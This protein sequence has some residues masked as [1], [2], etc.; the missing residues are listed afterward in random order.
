[1]NTLFKLSIT[2]ILLLTKCT[3]SIAQNVFETASTKDNFLIESWWVKPFDLEYKF[4][5]FN[6]SAAEYNYESGQVGFMSYSILNYNVIKGFGPAI[7]TRLLPD[8]LVPLGGL[9]YSFYREKFFLTANFTSEFKAQPD[10][11][12][13]S[14]I[15][16]RPPIT[17]KLKGFFQGQ[18][19]FN[20][21]PDGHLISFQQL[22]L[23]ADFGLVQSGL[24]INQFQAGSEWAYDIQ[25]GL[26]LRFEFQ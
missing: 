3:I 21:N 16:Y 5:I 24:A 7:G 8:K 15:Q 20:F 14:I 10:F 23:G 2:G 22:R 26:F 4:T 25:A 1:M 18:F 11:E 13:F 9:Q 17:E 12:L 6:L 19:S